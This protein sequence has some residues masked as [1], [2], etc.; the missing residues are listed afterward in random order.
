MEFKCKFCPQIYFSE[1]SRSD[2]ENTH[3]GHR[4]LCP[5]VDWGRTYSNSANLRRHIRDYHRPMEAVQDRRRQR[6]TA[7]ENEREEAQFQQRIA[8]GN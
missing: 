4:E 5:Y 2:H 6:E 3:T 8:S 1:Q 7:R